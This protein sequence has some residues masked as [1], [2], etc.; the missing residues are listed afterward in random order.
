MGYRICVIAMLLIALLGIAVAGAGAAAATAPVVKESF[1]PLAC[2]HDET[3]LGEEGCA[4]KSIL[5]TDRQIDALNARIF[6]RLNA[7]GRK[8]FVAGHNAWLKYR[9]AYCVSESD[10]YRGGT[11]AGVV[12]ARCVADVNV[13]HGKE[14]RGFISNLTQG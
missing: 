6:K 11:E 13:A 1:T 7:G 2:K 4:E 3:T 9:H 14:L 8:D 5:A 12:E 10:I